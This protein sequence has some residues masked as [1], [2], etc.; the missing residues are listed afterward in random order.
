MAKCSQCGTEFQSAFCPNCGT[1]ATQ[2]QPQTFGQQAPYYGQQQA[3]GQQVPYA[4]QNA[5]PATKKTPVWV[6][7]LCGALVFLLVSTCTK[8]CLSDS[9]SGSDSSKSST[10]YS[11]SG[12][13]AGNQTSDGVVGDY[14]VTFLSANY[15]TD[16]DPLLIVTYEFTNKSNETTS[17]F[18]A[19]SD[20]A[21]Q[22]GK[23]L[24][25]KIFVDVEGF[26]LST[27]TQEVKPGETLHVQCAYG[28]IDTHTDVNIELTEAFSLTN[29]D[30][31]TLTITLDN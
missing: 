31:V 24:D 30:K 15:Y 6:T 5:Q 14:K 18:S 29:N 13:N 16:S 20:K 25:R 7:I 2:A 28:L 4:G 17:F 3:N 21:F 26:D 22:N 1:P 12:N 9:D 11:D 27:R 23:E 19:I 10:G 8:S